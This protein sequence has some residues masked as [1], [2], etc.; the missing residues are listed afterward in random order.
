M[1][2]ACVATRSVPD[3]SLAAIHSCLDE[4]KART[5]RPLA[6]AADRAYVYARGGSSWIYFTHGDSGT[7]GRRSDDYG[8]L[9]TCGVT[10]AS[11]L[12]V[13]FLGETMQDPIIDLPER[14]YFVTPEGS[15]ELLFRREDGAFRYC[16]AQPFDRLNVR[17]ARK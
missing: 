17:R 3:Q 6:G 14:R 5:G 15:T 10:R 8:I 16:C 2:V 7:F 9:L 12:T 11:G 1:L 4:K 13:V